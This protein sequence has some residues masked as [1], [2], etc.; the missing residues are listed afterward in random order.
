MTN[1]IHKTTFI[2]RGAKII[3]NVSSGKDSSIWYNAVVRA[4]RKKI[5]MGNFSN[6]QDNCICHAEKHDLIIGDNVSIGHGAI[7]HGCTIKDNCI[8]GMGAI[9]MEG[10]EIEENCIIGAG[11]VITENKKI[12]GNSLVIGMPGKVM[13]ELNHGEIEHIK[14][15][16]A[17]YVELAKKNK[18][19]DV[20][21]P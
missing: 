3:G 17:D 18:E 14:E 16:A 10:V 13:R 21:S 1:K 11:A 12:S 20:L 5:M 15:N 4:D 7:I 9:V 19:I 2:A 6:I 8:I